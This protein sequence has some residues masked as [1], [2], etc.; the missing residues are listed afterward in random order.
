M[1]KKKI[2]VE[3]GQIWIVES[4]NMYADFHL[5]PKYNPAKR[6]AL[7]HIKRGEK[8]EI[9]HPYAWHFRTEDNVYAHCDEDVLLKCCI[10]FGTVRQDVA[11]SNKANLEEIL[12]LDLYNRSN[13]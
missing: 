10:L 3:V 8:I 4:D 11:W 9:R 13:N 6:K 1:E 12:R 7:I 2:E 5:P